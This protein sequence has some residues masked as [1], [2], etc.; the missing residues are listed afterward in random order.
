MRN[1][2]LGGSGWSSLALIAGVVGLAILLGYLVSY[3]D[4]KVVAALLLPIS[5]PL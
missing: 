2:G 3:G 5:S 4:V 1:R